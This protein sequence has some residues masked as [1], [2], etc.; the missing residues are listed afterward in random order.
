MDILSVLFEQFNTYSK[1]NPVVAGVVSLW[2]IAV[3]TWLCRNIPQNIW[4]F[5]R[6]QYTTTLTIDNQEI[7]MNFETYAGLLEWLNKSKWIRFSRNI[8]VTG[9]YFGDKRGPYTGIVVGIGEGTHFFRYKGKFFWVKREEQQAPQNGSK[10]H[11]KIKITCVGRDRKFLLDLID[12]FHPHENTDRLSVWRWSNSY[13]EKLTTI[14]RRSLETVITHGGLKED[15]VKEIEEFQNSR[16]WYIQRGLAHKLIYIFHGKSGTGK[17][18]LIKALA[19]RFNLGIAVINLSQMSD[20]TLAKALATAPEYSLI[21]IEDF[22]SSSAVRA[23]EG[24]Q[25]K[26]KESE[27]EIPSPMETLSGGIKLIEES[28]FLTLSGVLNAMDGVVSLDNKLVFMTT[29]ILDTIDPAVVRPGRVDRIVEI[30]ELN[31]SDIV[32]YIELMFPDYAI[33]GHLV[34]DDLPGCELQQLYFANKKDAV[35][36][37]SSI[38]TTQTT[39]LRAV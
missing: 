3:F 32:K 19:S 38:P 13:W 27:S 35:A 26:R 39:K 1:S 16:E 7:G 8:Q 21:L 17:T 15:I 22:D 18:T 6:T 5:L 30:S 9:R 12:D 29:N 4:L 24:M 20:E 25:K 2:G 11:S 10:I 37:V 14:P 31:N 34:F 28:S 23:R 36:F 33:P